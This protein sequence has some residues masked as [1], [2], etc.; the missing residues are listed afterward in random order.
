V[1]PNCGRTA[2]KEFLDGLGGC[3]RRH[4]PRQVL[5]LGHINSHSTEW[6]NSR[7]NARGRALSDSAAVLE[8]LLVNRG[9]A[10]NCVARRVRSIADIT[11]ATLDAFRRISGWRVAE[12]VETLSNLLYILMEVKERHR[13]V[14]ASAR[15]VRG[16][17]RAGDS[18]QPPRWKVKERNEDLHWAAVTA[19]AWSW[20]ASTTTTTTEEGV[21]EE[22]E[23]FR[24]A[25]TAICDTSMLRATQG[26]ARSRA[27]YWWNS[28]IA[29]LRA[30]CIQTRRRYQRFRRRRRRDE[31]ELSLRY[32][33]Y[34]ELRR[35]LQREIRVAKDR[36]WSDLVEAV[37]SDPWGRPYKVVTRK[38]RARG[39]PATT[40]MEPTLLAKVVRTLFPPARGHRGG[41]TPGD[42]TDDRLERR[43][44]SQRGRTVEGD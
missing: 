13:P 29:R 27:V 12:G 43:L 9:S 17:P 37:E 10:S 1:S 28:D 8:L 38:L 32:G 16:P 42:H 26:T 14:T 11:W 36:A 5:V 15:A 7:T 31:E 25:M 23:N 22:A 2:F 18:R 30:I 6:G 19:T 34:R 40:E 35:S 3:V 4:L 41:A 21:E 44:E 20:E 39:P 24:R 33:A